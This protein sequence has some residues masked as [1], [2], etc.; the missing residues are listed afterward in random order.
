MED[1]SKVIKN[2]PDALT[3]HH[4]KPKVLGGKDG[5]MSG[6]I[7]FV[8][9]KFHEAWHLLFNHMTAPEIAR[10]CNEKWTDPNFYMVAMTYDEY[11]EFISTKKG[12]DHHYV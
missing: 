9:R 3:R 11:H 8:K 12:G 4:R 6:N 1:K 7:S 2:D 5:D 10:E